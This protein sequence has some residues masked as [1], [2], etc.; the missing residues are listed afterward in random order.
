MKKNLLCVLA[1]FISTAVFGQILCSEERQLE[2]QFDNKA[3]FHLESAVKESSS[4]V[5]IWEEDFSG[6]FPQNWSTHTSNTQSGIAT[7]PWAWSTDGTWGYWNGQNGL[8]PSNAITST[9][10]SNGFLTSDTDSA[11]H[12]SYGQ[13]SGTTYEYIASYFTT[14]AIDLSMYPAVSL[15]FEHLF[16]YNNLTNPSFTPPTV[17]VS[18]DSIS[19][20]EYL[21]NNNTADNTQSSNPASEI[22][23]ITTVAGNQ[24][25][26]YIRFGWVSRC[27]Y[28]MVDDIKIIKTPD[29][30]LVCNEEAIGGWWIDYQTVGGLGQDYSFY[31]INQAIA[32][33]YAF[34][35]VLKN[36]GA[37]TQSA[38]LNVDVKNAA[39]ANVFSTIS[40]SLILAPA[41]QD[42]VAG[43]TAFTPNSTGLYNI[44]MWGVADSAGN[45]T[46]YTY[47][48]TANKMTTVTDYVYGKDNGTTSG[49]WRLN[50]VSPIPGGLEVSS[51][52]D[53]YVDTDL[54]S[55]DVHISDWSIPGA[56]VYVVLY[57]ED[58]SGG[59]P[60]PL[61]QSDNYS[62]KITDRGA[63]VNI[64]FLTPQSLTAAT[65]MYRIAVGSNIH[66]TDTVGVDVRS[67]AGYY[68]SDGLFDKDAILTNSTSGPRWYTISQIP[69]LR[70]NFEPVNVS[71]NGYKE[72]VFNIYPNPTDGVFY[73]DVEEPGSY[74]INV[75]NVL[76]AKIISKA[77]H[78]LNNHIDLSDCNKGIYTV[79]LI[80]ENGIYTDRLVIE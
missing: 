45:G 80:S 38:T 62:I 7:C 47:T 24:P 48:D 4:S 18:T 58:L 19:W 72:S 67:A 22:I 32:N 14:D 12:Y 20:T 77:V 73:F 39:G 36:N 76:G 25:T 74:D 16:R 75:Y 6:G 52:Y 57:E 9:S 71:V 29:N 69:M 56:E 21:V 31:P 78:T 33:P 41:E 63:W 44:E 10:A 61:A 28:W 26:V 54:Y 13:P 59:D 3:I 8:S 15:E 51:S 40:N 27:Y 23:N 30:L 50:R 66:P 65:K 79:E 42:T 5:I 1:L 2:Q 55:V 70:M 60:I 46:V 34:E 68:S 37:S 64:P 11:N 53:I 43:I 49:Y 35:A 17:Y